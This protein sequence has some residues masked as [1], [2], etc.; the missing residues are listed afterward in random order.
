[1]KPNIGILI[2]IAFFRTTA[3]SEEILTKITWAAVQREWRLLAGD[4]IPPARAG[5][6]EVLK[7]V[8]RLAAEPAP[9]APGQA[10]AALPP[11]AVTQI[12]VLESPPIT[13]ATYALRGRVRC[14]GVRGQGYIEMW[15]VFAGNAAYFSRTMAQ[16][17]PMRCLKGTT[18]WYDFVLP[19][20]N[21]QG[22]PSPLRLLLNVALPGPGTV[23]LGPL[24]LVEFSPGENPLAAK[25]GAWWDERQGGL[26]G[27]VFGVVVGCFGA[28]IGGLASKGKARRFVLA[29]LKSGIPIG[30]FMLVV[31]VGAA[32]LRQP[33]HVW[34][35]LAIGGGLTLFIFSALLPGIRRR[36]Q[37]IELRRID[38]MDA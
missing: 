10:C 32:F 18:D 5:D 7:V 13:Q 27:A 11:Q 12:L 24:E 21:Q 17:G 34:F 3:S 33:Y 26:I 6:A 20:M 16:Q 30:G 23:Y 36:Y 37:E 28:A 38:A 2:L 1:M 31:G 22:G 19:F 15:N 35:P 29:C 14:E 9:S 25:A 4:V 8:S